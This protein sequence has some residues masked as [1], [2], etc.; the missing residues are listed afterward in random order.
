MLPILYTD[1]DFLRSLLGVSVK[2]LPDARLAAR[3]L[4]KELT[5]D[6]NS[7]VSNH[8][9]LSDAINMGTATVEETAAFDAITM[10]SAYFCAKL[11][12]P[13]LQLGASQAVGD[14]KNTLERFSTMDWEKL[15]EQIG[16]R[17]AFYKKVA[18]ANITLEVSTTATF[19]PFTLV[20][21]AYD[22]VTGV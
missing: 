9:T 7:W 20:G 1:T 6:L 11:V 15:T 10:Y 17:V 12:I 4:E 5:M 19:K 13:S 2:D 18:L 21:S 16:E 22:P 3:N 8:A 14:G